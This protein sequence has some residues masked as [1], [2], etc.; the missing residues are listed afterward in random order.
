[1]VLTGSDIREE[2]SGLP[3]CEE[4]RLVVR[5]T[6]NSTV[7]GRFFLIVETVGGER[8]EIGFEKADV[9]EGN[10]VKQRIRAAIEARERRG[11][12]ED[13]CLCREIGPERV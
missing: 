12:T 8:Y 10:R 11:Q 7:V 9:D 4:E 5:A 2:V 13:E 6:V 1:V 3:S